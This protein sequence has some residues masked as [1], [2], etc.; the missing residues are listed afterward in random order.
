MSYIRGLRR[1]IGRERVITPDVRA[2]IRDDTCRLLLQRRGDFGTCGLRAGGMEL[3]ESAV[4]A[5]A[6]EVAEEPGLRG[7]RATPFG[8]YSDL[9]HAVTY[10]NGD[11]IQPFTLAFLSRNGPASRWPMATRRCNSPSSR[12]MRY[13]PLSNSSRR[14]ARPSSTSSGL[15]P[16]A[17]SSSMKLG[18]GQS[19]NQ[20]PSSLTT[21]Y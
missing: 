4:T 19:T 7:I 12:S 20:L 6:R 9:R 3:G 1:F 14:T 18:E 10:P 15:S 11:Q 13:H 21:D 8:I 2:I 17:N 16:M 5:L